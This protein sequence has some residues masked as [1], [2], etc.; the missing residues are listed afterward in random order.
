[1]TEGQKYVLWI[2]GLFRLYGA[3]WTIFWIFQ[4]SIHRKEQENGINQE[5][6]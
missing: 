2:E 1:M 4:K 6:R 3:K 5:E